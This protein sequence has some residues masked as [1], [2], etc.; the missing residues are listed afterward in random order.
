MFDLK[1]KTILVAGGAGYLGSYI[2]DLILKSEAN[3]CIAD[4]DN[5]KMDKVYES[6]K[7]KYSKEKILIFNL[8][9]RKEASIIKVI[10]NC[11]AH[12][13]DLKGLVNAT[14]GTT[15]KSLEDLNAKDF[16]EANSIN[17]T[18]SFLLARYAAKKIKQNGSIVMF[19]S[20]YGLVSPNL[21]FYP[22][23]MNPNPIEYG[24]GKAGLIQMTKYLAAYYGQY[25]I[26]VNAIAPGPFPNI[27][28]QGN[29][30]SFF[31]D[32]LKKSTMLGRL[33]EARETAAP[34]VFLLSEQS[35]YIT[36]Q[37]LSVDGGWT[38]W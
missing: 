29:D 28:K 33:G 9:M 13:G 25:N 35:S 18:G 19:G 4:I 21:S 3:L 24:A 8:D 34:T 5:Q 31:I 6:L 20:M 12:F 27:Q 26:R 16:N 10:N 17:L 37:T 36:G 22:D 1:N 23:E 11:V 2:C 14:Y 38:S 30:N 32:K 15:I 7:K